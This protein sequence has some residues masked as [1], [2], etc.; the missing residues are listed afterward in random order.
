MPW[1]KIAG[2]TGALA[3][4]LGAYGAHGMKSTHDSFKDV[5]KTASIY[6]FVHTLA[7][8]GV[9]VS[10]LSRRN[11]M[12]ANSL[13]SAG[14]SLFCGSCYIVGVTSNRKYGMAAPIGGM[15]FI[16]GWLALAIL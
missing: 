14:I 12:V 3:V 7:I 11:K 9:A 5:F 2:C 4:G 16:G 6:H 1:L 8:L 15:A 10:P 13:F